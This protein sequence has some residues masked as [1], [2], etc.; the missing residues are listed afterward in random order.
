MIGQNFS[1][2]LKKLVDCYGWR[3]GDSEKGWRELYK[4]DMKE[5]FT[6]VIEITYNDDYMIKKVYKYSY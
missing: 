4:Y 2:V 1:E 3:C 6:Q 5:D